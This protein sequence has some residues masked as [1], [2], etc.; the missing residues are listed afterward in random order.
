MWDR[1][2]ELVHTLI[3]FIKYHTYHFYHTVA[4]CAYFAAVF[5][6]GHGFYASFGGFLFLLTIYGLMNNE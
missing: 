3:H 5:I 6:E 4:H 1:F 2:T